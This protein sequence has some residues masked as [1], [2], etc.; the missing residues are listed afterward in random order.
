MVNSLPPLKI[1]PPSVALLPESVLLFKFKVLPLLTSIPPPLLLLTEPFV[2][3]K[4]S[5]LTVVPVPEILKTRVASFPLTVV[6]LTPFPV[7]FKLLLIN[8]SP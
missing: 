2:I 8:V 3:F 4:L 7:M 5:K 1:P 6:L